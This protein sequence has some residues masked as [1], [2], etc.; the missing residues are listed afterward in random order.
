MVEVQQIMTDIA[1]EPGYR[2]EARQILDQ[3]L[4]LL[5]HDRRAK[6]VPDLSA[7]AALLDR[8]TDDA[9]LSMTAAMRGADAEN[10]G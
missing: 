2:H 6:L 5:P 1:A 9:I 7:Q 10:A 4:A 3:M 8:L